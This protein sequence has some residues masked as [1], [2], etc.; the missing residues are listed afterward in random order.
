MSLDLLTQRCVEKQRLLKYLEQTP[1]SLKALVSCPQ[2]MNSLHR[3]LKQKE[4]K[5]GNEY[6]IECIHEPSFEWGNAYRA[7]DLPET[8]VREIIHLALLS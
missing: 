3:R 8:L 7:I 6:R 5:N 2:V 4:K 1:L